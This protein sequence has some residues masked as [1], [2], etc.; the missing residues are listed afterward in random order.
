MRN[1]TRPGVAVSLRGSLAAEAARKI[2]ESADPQGAVG[3]FVHDL[4]D[5]N[6]RD[7][8]HYFEGDALVI[9]RRSERGQFP[10]DW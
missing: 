4:L 2:A 10:P 7:V 3:E 1:A 9:G 8:L 5:S 6:A